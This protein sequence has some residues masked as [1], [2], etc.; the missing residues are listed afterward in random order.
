MSAAAASGCL[1]DLGVR[2]SELFRLLSTVRSTA[3]FRLGPIGR[4]V[5]DCSGGATV[6]LVDSCWR[7]CY[8]WSGPRVGETRTLRMDGG[9]T[10]GAAQLSSNRCVAMP[11]S[12]TIR[13]PDDRPEGVALRLVA[14]ACFSVYRMAS[15]GLGR[16]CVR[17]NLR[18]CLAVHPI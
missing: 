14:A 11:E 3:C 8:R 10:C 16:T 15:L 17:L 18:S 2:R 12:F 9:L 5:P 13:S 1:L 6:L 7:T 4:L